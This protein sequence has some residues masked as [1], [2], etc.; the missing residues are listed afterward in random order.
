[1]SLLSCTGQTVG[2]AQ[3]ESPN[4][5]SS[6]KELHPPTHRLP[7]A[8]SVLWAGRLWPFPEGREEG[9]ATQGL[10]AR[11]AGPGQG[12][13]PGRSSLPLQLLLLGGA[14]QQSH[15]SA[16]DLSTQG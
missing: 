3:M 10:T 14:G 16:E 1:M 2:D 12:L 8:D 6:E 11:A 4:L 15:L 7:P 5:C 9:P 13:C